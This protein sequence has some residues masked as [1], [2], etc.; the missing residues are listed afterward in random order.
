MVSMDRRTA[1]YG[2]SFGRC[3]LGWGSLGGGASEQRDV[4]EERER[5]PYLANMDSCAVRRGD[6][7]WVH[8]AFHHPSS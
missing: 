2:R 7:H 8:L 4:I 1:L 5:R 6:V 3:P